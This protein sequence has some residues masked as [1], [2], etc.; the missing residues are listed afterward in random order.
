V[1]AAL[2]LVLSQ[3]TGLPGAA[4]CVGQVAAVSSRPPCA[5]QRRV[6]RPDAAAFGRPDAAAFGRPARRF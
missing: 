5:G 3:V 4:V 6:G 2:G 1:T